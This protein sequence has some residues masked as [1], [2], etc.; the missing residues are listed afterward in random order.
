MDVTFEDFKKLELRVGKVLSVEDHPDAN[1]LYLITVNIGEET[2]RVVAGIKPYYA[3]EE[4]V[5]KSVVV[6]TNLEPKV[7]RGVES[8][9]MILASRAGDGLGILTIDRELPPGSVIS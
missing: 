3:K 2:R 9:G 6:V 5:G 1:K 4:L 8:K 7:I